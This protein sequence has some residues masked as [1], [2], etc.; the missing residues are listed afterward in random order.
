LWQ[1]ELI[2]GYYFCKGH[3]F[4]VDDFVNI[5][6]LGHSGENELRI[7]QK[8]KCIIVLNSRHETTLNWYRLCELDYLELDSGTFLGKSQFRARSFV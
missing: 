4:F 7:I 1:V 5:C 8:Q 6:W 3:R 2:F